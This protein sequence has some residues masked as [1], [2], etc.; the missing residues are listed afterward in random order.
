MELIFG[1]CP[2]RVKECRELCV[3][4]IV[5]NELDPAKNHVG[6]IHITLVVWRRNIPVVV[7]GCDA[8]SLVG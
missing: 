5:I 1:D 4:P 7:L 3:W 8:C 2:S 6:Y